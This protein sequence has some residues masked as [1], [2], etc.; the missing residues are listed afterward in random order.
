MTGSEENRERIAQLYAGMSEEELKGLADEAWSLTDAGKGALRAELA[1]R[2]LD[3]EM[4]TTPPKPA[5]DL[6]LVTVRR[7]RDMPD[8]VLAQS[9]LESAGI[10]SFLVDETTIRMDWLWSNALG[11]IK[12]CAKPEDAG[13]AL[14][15]L[16]QKIPE[17][18]SI[19]GVGEFEQPLCPQ[20]KSLD[21]SFEDLDKRVAYAGML[22]TGFPIP[23]RRRRWKCRSCGY[24]WHLTEESKEQS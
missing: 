1:R 9:V 19:E 17:K 8:A 20:C 6:N 5:P 24:E 23:L 21:V 22:L 13:E 7:F 18:F 14:Q 15:L 16:A 2:G 12:L 11:G 10:E 4:A 3:F